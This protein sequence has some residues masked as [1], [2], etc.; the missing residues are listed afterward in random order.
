MHLESLTPASARDYIRG[1]GDLAG[2]V[3]V[4]AYALNTISILPP[5]AILS[6]AAGLA[7]GKIWG[8]ILLMAGAMLGTGATFFISRFFARGFIERIL[9]G[10]FKDLDDKLGKRG[11]MT[12]LFFRVV[13]IIPYEALNYASGLSKIKYRDYA[14]ASFLGF[15]PGIAIS[16][17]FG[18]TLGRAKQLRDLFSFRFLIAA[19]AL[20]ILILIPL[21]Y[22][23]L[24]GRMA[25][26]S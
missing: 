19:L 13:P 11:F 16:V 23:R 6:L 3:Y 22:R 2:V 4:M 1:F 26:G 9:R 10:K 24:K 14:L 20:I 8:S 15:I 17:F 7:F 25:H 18:D 12:V 5:I 21:I